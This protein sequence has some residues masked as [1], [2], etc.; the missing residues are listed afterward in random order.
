MN[1]QGSPASR[2]A[3]A[4]LT[5]ERIVQRLLEVERTTGAPSGLGGVAAEARAGAL[6]ER[7]GVTAPG[8]RRV[9][10][11]RLEDRERG[12]A[13]PKSAFGFAIQRGE[14]RE[15]VERP[16]RPAVAQRES[17]LERL[18]DVAACRG[19]VGLETRDERAKRE[20]GPGLVARLPRRCR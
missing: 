14:T 3:G 18:D 6:H 16:R 20:C 15:D 1:N 17:D 5:V 12:A 2:D 8:R 10:R 4:L 19:E 11:G 13:Q 7:L 9:L